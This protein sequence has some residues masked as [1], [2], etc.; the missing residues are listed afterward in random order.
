MTHS[1]DELI[2]AAVVRDIAV[3]WRKNANPYPA[4]NVDATEAWV[5]A[6]PLKPYIKDV[7]AQLDNV[8]GI[9]SE[10]RQAAN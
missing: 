4:P 8:A 7:L 1:T 2:L 3:Q 6:N 5:N 10:L 9:I